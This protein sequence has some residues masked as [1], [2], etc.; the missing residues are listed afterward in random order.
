[1]KTTFPVNKKSRQ[2]FCYRLLN[3]LCVAGSFFLLSFV[4]AHKVSADQ[5]DIYRASN[6]ESLSNNSVMMMAQDDDGFIWLGTYDGLNRYD[7]KGVRVFRHEFDNP[8]TLSGNVINELHK[9]EK[10]YLWVLTTMGL[11]KFST[12]ELVVKEHYTD[13]RASRHVLVSDTLGHAFAISPDNK[14]L[15]YDPNI[16][17]F[18]VHNQ[19]DWVA[20]IR[21][22][23]GVITDNNTLWLFPEE[24]FAYKIHFDFSNGYDPGKAIIKWRK[25]KMGKDDT[26]SV[27]E[28]PNGFFV[29]SSNGDLTFHDEVSGSG[30]LIRNI[31]KEIERYGLISGIVQYENDILI[32]FTSN[33][34]MRLDF[35]NG[36]NPEMLFEEV[37]VFS[38]LH[39]NRQDLV[40]IATDGRGLYKMCHINKRYGSIHSTQIPDLT[41]PIRTF[42][43]D[44]QN[45]LWIGTKGDGLII[46]EDY[47]TL[48]PET[49][50]IPPDRIIRYGL[51]PG[52][53]GDL[54]TNQVFV[55]RESNFY[56]GRIWIAGRG[57]GVSY[58]NGARRK[59]VNLKHPELVDI[60]DF[61]EENDTVLWFASATRGL[62]KVITDGGDGIL[63]VERFIFKRDKY[64]CNEIYS[65]AY[66]GHDGLYVG[67]RGGIGIVRFDINT[68]EYDTL[69]DVNDRIPGIGDIISLAYSGDG[70]LYFGSSTGGGIVDCRNS[71]AP[72]LTKVITN[73]DGLVNDMVH[74]IIPTNDGDVWMSTNK[75]IARYNMNTEK[76]HNVSNL[77]GDINEFCDNSGYLSPQN[78]DII[79]GA[80][81]G[82]VCI[83]SDAKYVSSNNDSQ[84][85]I[86]FTGLNVNG[87]GRVPP[88]DAFSKGL[89][90]NH[91][92]D[93]ITISFAA[94]DYIEGDFI[95]Y[96]YK[97][98][99]LND[100]WINLGNN[101]VVTFTNLQPGKYKLHVRCEKDGEASNTTEFVL[102]IK[103]ASAWYAT[104]LS[105]IL[106][107]IAFILMVSFM[108]YQ[109]RNKYMRKKK[110]LERQIYQK[111][112]ERLYADRK[113]FFTNITHEFCSPLTMI[114]G[115]CDTLNQHVESTEA[116]E[117]KPYIDTLYRNTKHLN[118]LVQE[119]LDVRY[120]D[121]ANLVKLNV[122][123]ISVENIFKRWVY[124][125]EEIARQN[126][127]DFSV[128]IDQPDLRW[129][130]DVSCMSK[131]V[132]NLMSNAFKYTPVGGKIRV[133][134]NLTPKRELRFEVF[135]TGQGVSEKN[136]AS[137]FDKFAVF[138]NVDSNRYRDMSSRHGLGLFI[139]HEMAVKL[140]A[141]IKVENSEGE[142]IKFIVIFP[143]MDVRQQS[144]ELQLPVQM[145]NLPQ[146]DDRP[147]IL[148]IDDNQDI[149]WLLSNILGK[150]HVVTLA[151]T[152]A[153]AREAL[154]KQ[155]PAL[156]ISDILMPDESGIEFVKYIREN[157]F[158][159]NLPVILL[160]AKISEEDKI[161][162][163]NAGADAYVTKPFNSD[164][165]KTLVARLLQRKTADKNY[166]R[167]PESTVTIDSGKEIST[168]GKLFLDKI[169]KYITKNLEDE[170][171]LSPE[172]IAQ[173]MNVDI[174]TLY[175]RFKKHT[176]YTPSEYVKKIR[177]A[178]AANLILTTDL[179]IQEIIFQVGVNNKTV[180]Y[181]DFKKIYGMTPK[182]YRNS[183][184]LIGKEQ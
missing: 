69:A 51:N 22:S 53:E 98:E 72:V 44:S 120:M 10:G 127:I 150:D 35:E 156:I 88:S 173:A 76:L 91:D 114:M 38:I 24:D 166:Y 16:K 182:E 152:W 28:S 64:Q 109:V 159:R 112:Q 184:Y 31:A 168:E 8:A 121:D 63:K 104:R 15:Y 110:E 163:Y 57:P 87:Y 49:G 144:E 79:F 71:Q 117:L 170:S 169:R 19:P 125:Y 162:G 175:R 134:A 37:G 108:M 84:A 78:G 100:T 171:K 2:S 103:V 95:N 164:F 20:E 147:E 89:K 58:T 135:N 96:W 83:P 47:L 86:V 183:K 94:L 118:D 74:S 99:G 136:L 142:Y 9:A 70:T 126:D 161:E 45:N 105:Y 107:I 93:V 1:M 11:D 129:N 101:P 75:G 122:Q 139:C 67:C 17:Q 111:E 149:L 116:A 181:S 138:N 154:E 54:T 80:L 155:I 56:P 119:I 29:V 59:I 46:L 48:L 130:T 43:T 176:P 30:R 172:A 143:P 145:D 34:V 66:D 177:Y 151:K 60:H 6:I 50:E 174:R 102:P 128:D 92:D 62:L 68:G 158:T 7:G 42:Y 85:N 52:A 157:K 97:M 165:L 146:I 137:L 160:S 73:R 55:I 153:E 77:G 115:M 27:F 41:K 140:G 25:V 12:D 36:Y 180:F 178:F 14:F 4:Q 33:G 141:E 132:T 124:G 26:K 106:Y 13:I 3:M 133:S 5:N 179:T 90:F 167:S 82:I 23:H 18:H 21:G 81:N 65:L 61:F 148:V 113:A 40:W 32:S 131:I 39:D 123:P